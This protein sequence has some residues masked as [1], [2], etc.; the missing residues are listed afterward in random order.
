MGP[1]TAH[2]STIDNLWYSASALNNVNVD[3]FY[4]ACTYV[5]QKN[6]K[7]PMNTCH[8]ETVTSKFKM[9]AAC[10]SNRPMFLVFYLHSHTK[11]SEQ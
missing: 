4:I 8:V 7:N 5:M 6:S 1:S 2:R 3:D 10:I 9:E 11:D